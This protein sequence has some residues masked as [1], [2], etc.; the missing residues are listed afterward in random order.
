M[1]GKVPRVYNVEKAEIVE[2]YRDVVREATT[3]DTETKK[4][5]VGRKWKKRPTEGN[6]NKKSWIV[7]ED[8]EL[9]CK[10]E[11]RETMGSVSWLR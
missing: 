8:S 1:T 7:V 3:K 10:E 4:G 2:V 5:F 11:A 9:C 6:V